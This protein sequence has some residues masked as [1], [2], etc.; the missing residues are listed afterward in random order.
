MHIEIQRER[1]RERE[2]KSSLSSKKLGKKNCLLRYRFLAIQVSL[3]ITY[4][5]A[6]IEAVAQTAHKINFTIDQHMIP[7]VHPSV[8][9][10]DL[11]R[12]K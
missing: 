1:E 10:L 6:Q 12:S 11:T 5:G 8:E 7:T 3:I 2:L 4:L 9:L